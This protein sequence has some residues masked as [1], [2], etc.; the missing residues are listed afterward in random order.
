MAFADALAMT[1]AIME[2]IHSTKVTKDTKVFY[3]YSDKHM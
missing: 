2:V 3:M 1:Q